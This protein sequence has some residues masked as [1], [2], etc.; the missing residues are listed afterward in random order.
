MPGL[1]S[2]S[3]LHNITLGISMLLLLIVCA[4][5]SAESSATES[6]TKAGDAM[7]TDSRGVHRR[8]MAVDGTQRDFSYFVPGNSAG[9]HLPIVIYLHGYGDNMR[10]ILGEGIVTSASSKWM[11]VAER[12][13]F[14]VF[15]PL[16]LK[17]DGW[18]SKAGWND[19]RRDAKDNPQVDDVVFIRQLINFAVENL[20]GDRRRVYVTGM[21]NGGHMAMRVAMEMSSEVAAVAPIVALLPKASKCSPPSE[22]VPILMMFGTA[23]PIAPF[24]GGSM[25]GGR[26]EV[27]SARE[28]VNTWVKWNKLENVPEKTSGVSDKSS[29]DNSTIMRRTREASPGGIA[30]IAYEILGGGHTEPSQTAEM[31]RLLKAAQGNQNNDIEM[32]VTIWEFFKTRSR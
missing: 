23:D 22:P 26:G 2:K 14:L 28:T 12:E 19:C 15:Y 25:K 29:S 10:H 8:T 18:R 9:T 20:N 21:S 6:Q 32:A 11:A 3:I 17:G 13:G 5:T 27:M 16:G 1:P 31:N 30:V 4:N 24:E 7:N